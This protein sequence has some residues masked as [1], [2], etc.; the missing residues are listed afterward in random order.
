MALINA[1]DHRLIKDNLPFDRYL[2]GST[3]NLMAFD[4]DRQTVVSLNVG[5]SRGIL[6]NYNSHQLLI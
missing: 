1:I 3:L 6:V 2:S 4:L 5:D